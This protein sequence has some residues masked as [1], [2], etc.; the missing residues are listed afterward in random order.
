MDKYILHID[1]D[2]FFASCE[3]SHLPHLKGMP[4]VVGEE[5]GIACAMTQEAKKVGCYSWYAYI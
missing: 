4:V 5:R 2:N 3:I 1:G